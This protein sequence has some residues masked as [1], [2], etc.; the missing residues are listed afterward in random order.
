MKRFAM[1]PACDRE[2][3][4]PSDRRFHAQPNACPRCGPHLELWDA[5]GAVLGKEEEALLK[6]AID[7]VRDGQILAL[8]GIGGFQLI[9]DARNAQRGSTPENAQ[10][11]GGETFC[12]DVSLA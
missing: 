3:H 9:V 6:R 12:V 7:I 11:P 5:K 2:Y 1:C 4:D 8:K 10:A